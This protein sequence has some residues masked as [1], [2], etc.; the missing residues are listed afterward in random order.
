MKYIAPSLIVLLSSGTAWAAQF[1]DPGPVEQEITAQAKSFN[2]VAFPDEP[3]GQAAFVRFVQ[4]ARTLALTAPGHAALRAKLAGFEAN[5]NI[6]PHSAGI[7]REELAPLLRAYIR[8]R[9]HDDAAW[10]LSRLVKFRTYKGEVPNRENPEFAEASK[11]LS[12]LSARLKLK[13]KD[14][15]GNFF[16]ISLAGGEPPLGI[17]GH[18]DVV[19]AEAEGWKYPPFDGTIAEG[20]VWGRGS[21]DDK[22]AVISAIYGLAALREARVRLRN[23][24]VILIGTAEESTWEDVDYLFRRYSPPPLNVIVDAEFPVVYGE[25]GVMG[26]RVS[27]AVK[28]AE[29]VGAAWEVAGVS[30]GVQATI[31]PD[32]AEVRLKSVQKGREAALKEVAELARR[33]G[34]THKKSRVSISV[35]AENIEVRFGGV[36]AH[37][38]DPGLG[39]NAIA[40][41]V[42]FVTGLLGVPAG[43]RGC[44]MRFLREHIGFKTDGAG[45]GVNRRHPLLGATTVNL[46][47]W[48]ETN[49]SAT[50]AINIRFPVGLGLDDIKSAVER[51]I[52]KFN[53]RTGCAL[54][55]TARGMPPI[56]AD[57]NSDLVRTLVYSF[58]SSTGIAAE[59]VTTGGT[60]YA[61]VFPNAVAFGP[62]MPGQEKLDHAANERFPT[63]QL[64]RNAGI[65]ATAMLLLAG[66]P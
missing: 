1:S 66:Q 50:A 57:V 62:L 12:E 59:P 14:L 29:R 52:K 42:E 17:V 46:G 60:S 55:S 61:K 30:G 39:H 25:K 20:F 24:I 7:T 22:G 23:R 53:E 21:A 56:L 47:T 9:Y 40:D 63:D 64:T 28:E 35:G 18:V 43:G 36:A 58:N 10:S 54:S 31:V 8:L 5:P 19:P 34:E 33:F 32:R 15:E 6:G 26:V 27:T 51:R 41:M 44:M 48:S 37:S 11:F 3:D 49:G 16:E 45:L 4:T 65:F 2:G 38:M 13:F